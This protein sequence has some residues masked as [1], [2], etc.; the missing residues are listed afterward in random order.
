MFAQKLIIHVHILWRLPPP[1]SPGVASLPQGPAR[2]PRGSRWSFQHRWSR[3]DPALS[4]LCLPVSPP[5]PFLLSVA[6]AHCCAV[7]WERR[8]LGG[9]CDRALS[10]VPAVVLS[11]L[12]TWQIG[13]APHLPLTNPPHSAPEKSER[14]QK[15]YNSSSVLKRSKLW[16]FK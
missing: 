1:L 3:W 5:V 7:L 2:L 11:G 15:V 8:L 12:Q 6:S 13:T 10:S 16:R 14:S 4:L 9:T